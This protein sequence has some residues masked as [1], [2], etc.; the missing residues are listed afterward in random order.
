MTF[1]TLSDIM[2][3]ASGHF[4]RC[5]VVTER[6]SEQMALCASAL[7]MLAGKGA[8]YDD[9]VRYCSEFFADFGRELQ[10]FCQGCTIGDIQDDA[11]HAERYM[12]DASLSLLENMIL[13]VREKALRAGYDDLC[14]E[15][16]A[17]LEFFECGSLWDESKPSRVSA[18]YRKILPDAVRFSR[19]AA[20]HEK[21]ERASAPAVH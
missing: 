7:R 13:F 16:K 21:L 4:Q 20:I 10:D 14:R 11:A 8:A 1:T 17:L 5:P 15:E 18:V 12:A 3:E 2:K 6:W 9:A 19:Y